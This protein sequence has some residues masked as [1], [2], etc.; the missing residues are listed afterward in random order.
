M[1]QH[2]RY[3][4]EIAVS[5]TL[6]PFRVCKQCGFGKPITK[7]RQYYGGR[8]GR[9]TACLDCERIN[10]R[11]KYLKKKE[12]LTAAEEAEIAAI[13]KLY[14]TQRER[15]LCPPNTASRTQAIKDEVESL[16]NKYPEDTPAGI[17][18][19]L[20]EWLTK[21]LTEEPEYYVG[22]HDELV[23][24]YRKVLRVDKDTRTVHYDTTHSKVL[25]EILERF[26]DYEDSYY[27]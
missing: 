4:G 26:Y 24:K 2:K 8:K 13:N 17:P 15:C 18:H 21:P 3:R 11:Y 19:E 25:S 23:K 7:Y 6:M 27:K 12:V 22:I 9:Y 14:N 1:G 16:L 10:S 20:Q 5:D